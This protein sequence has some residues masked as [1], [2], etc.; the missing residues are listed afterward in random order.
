MVEENPN[1]RQQAGEHV[2][3][4]VR[5]MER[6]YSMKNFTYETQHDKIMQLLV[7]QK[8]ADIQ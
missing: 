7:N 6:A 1:F 5:N 4:E 3:Q 8:P 2:T